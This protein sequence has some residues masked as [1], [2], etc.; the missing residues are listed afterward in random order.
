MIDTT[1]SHTQDARLGFIKNTK[2]GNAYYLR[3]IFD[4][5]RMSWKSCNWKSNLKKKKVSVFGSME[6]WK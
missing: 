1:Q 2:R 6:T 5:F 3:K 4:G